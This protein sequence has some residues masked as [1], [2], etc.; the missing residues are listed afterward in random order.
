MLEG[1]S[2]SLKLIIKSIRADVW[3]QSHAIKRVH[4]V[5]PQHSRATRFASPPLS[6]EPGLGW[7]TSGQGRQVSGKGS[8]GW[9]KSNGEFPWAAP[10]PNPST[11]V[12]R[13]SPGS[14][15]TLPLPSP[16]AALPAPVLLRAGRPQ[17]SAPEEPTFIYYTCNGAALF[18][19]RK[20]KPA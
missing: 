8:Q 17:P 3:L 10:S 20:V 19:Y 12:R 2:W 18:T 6:T 5:Q 7:H 11:A 1:S 14:V 4:F 9:K 13:P 16:R 15:L